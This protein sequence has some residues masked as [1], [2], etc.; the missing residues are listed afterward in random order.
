MQ[1]SFGLFY[2][3]KSFFQA[4]EDK[5]LFFHGGFTLKKG[6]ATAPDPALPKVPNQPLNIMRA[7]QRP[8][9]PKKKYYTK[10]VQKHNIITR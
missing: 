5:L 7:S 2:F 1:A 8:C 6:G 4:V 3:G 10:I 9:G